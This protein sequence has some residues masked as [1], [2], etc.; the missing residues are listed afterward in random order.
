M[1]KHQ[2]YFLARPTDEIRLRKE[3]TVRS[4]TTIQFKIQFRSTWRW[5]S[6]YILETQADNWLSYY[7]KFP[8]EVEEC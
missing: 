1:K 4:W 7:T 3:E 8:K 2:R 5:T 6:E